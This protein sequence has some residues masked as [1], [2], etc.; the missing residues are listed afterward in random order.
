MPSFPSPNPPKNRYHMLVKHS[1]AYL[2]YL[3]HSFVSE[4]YKASSG[5][6]LKEQH[7]PPPPNQTWELK[8][9]I[10]LQKTRI[11]TCSS[12]LGV[13]VLLFLFICNIY[14]PLSI[15]LFVFLFQYL[16]VYHKFLLFFSFTTNGYY[17]YSPFC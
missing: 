2:T 1:P 6:A 15:Y 16:W 4:S 14:S 12:P 5:M 8:K 13:S 7:L 11:A 10:Y 17:P 3:G 9:A